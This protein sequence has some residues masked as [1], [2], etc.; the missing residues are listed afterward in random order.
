MGQEGRPQH[1]PGGVDGGEGGDQADVGQPHGAEDGAAVHGVENPAEIGAED[2][3]G[4]GR[5][6]VGEA[7]A[8]FG[9]PQLLQAPGEVDEQEEAHLLGETHQPDGGEGRDA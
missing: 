7:D 1:R 8:T 5:G 6:G 9:Q 3:R 4:Q 2:E